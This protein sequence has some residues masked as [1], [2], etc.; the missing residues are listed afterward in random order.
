MEFL[1]AFAV[2]L[3]IL[4]LVGVNFFDIGLLLLG[5]L[6]FLCL[7]MF[8]FF[9]FSL[10]RL[11][12]C[13]RVKAR[14]KEIGEKE[15]SRFKVAWYVIGKEEASSVF[16]AEFLGKRLF[17]KRSEDTGVLLTKKGGVFDLNAILAIALGFVFSFAMFA[18]ILYAIAAL[19]KL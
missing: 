12:T 18:G 15:N 6:D 14:F 3:V 2:L 7:V 4:I 5:L 10:F 8:C 11:F 19:I 13:K 1:V 16:P 17:Y 9:A